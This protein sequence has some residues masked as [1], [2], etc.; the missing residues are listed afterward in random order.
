MTNNWNLLHINQEFKDVFQEF[1]ISAF[2]RCTNLYDLLGC[3]NIV[4]GKLQK[5]KRQR[6]PRRKKLIL[7]LI[8]EN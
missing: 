3:K 4:D 1:S 7:I 8:L 5:L 6:A 2:K